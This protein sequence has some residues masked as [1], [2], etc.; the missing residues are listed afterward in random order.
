MDTQMNTERDWFTVFRTDQGNEWL[1]DELAEGRL[2]QGWV[3][4]DWASPP[5]TGS[6]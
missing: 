2:R 6:R 5:W 1:Y 3:R 4:P